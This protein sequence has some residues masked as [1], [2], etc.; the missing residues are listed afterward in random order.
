MAALSMNVGTRKIRSGATP[1]SRSLRSMKRLVT[2]NPSTQSNAPIQRW[3][4]MDSTRTSEA[5]NERWTHLKRTA[6]HSE[7]ARHFSHGSPARRKSK[8]GHIGL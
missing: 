3:K 6:F 2:T 4:N 1:D 8:R 5:P 7:P